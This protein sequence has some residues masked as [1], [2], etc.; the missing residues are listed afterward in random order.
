MKVIKA[1]RALLKKS[2]SFT[3]LRKK[4]V[5]FSGDTFVATKNISEFERKKIRDKIIAQA[6]KDRLQKISLYLLSFIV[7]IALITLLIWAIVV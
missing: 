3:E 7:S 4:Y 1:N 5:K 6:K 2:R